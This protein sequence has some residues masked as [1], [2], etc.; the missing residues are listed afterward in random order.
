MKKALVCLALLF[1]LLPASATAG[2]TGLGIN[3]GPLFPMAQEDQESGFVFGLKIRTDLVGPL[4][5]EPNFNFGSFGDFTLDGVGTRSGSD[6]KYYGLDITI[7]GGMGSV[8]PKPYLFIGGG[9]YNI[10][11]SG[12][13]RS[14][15]SG[16]SFGGGLAVG[17]MQNWDIDIRGRMNIASSAGSTS[18][19]SFALTFGAV[20]FFGQVRR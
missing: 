19:K 13:S 7:G 11:R 17:I 3:V 15:K 5:F 8:G 10:K 9:V 12:D 6:L 14:N 4:G 20:Y 1:L 16:W 2:K 18:R